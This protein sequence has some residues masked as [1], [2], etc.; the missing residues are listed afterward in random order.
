[1]N[2]PPP[3]LAAALAYQATPGRIQRPWTPAEIHYLISSSGRRTSIRKQAQRLGR[4]IPSV[5]GQLT[6]LRH[7]G[8]I[9]RAGRRKNTQ[10]RWTHDDDMRLLEMIH[11]G[12]P[13][14]LVA[15]RIGR[16]EDSVYQRVYQ[17]GETVTRLRARAIRTRTAEEVAAL[18]GRSSELV[19][20]WLRDGELKSKRG[21]SRPGRHLLIADA[22]LV[23]FLAYRPAW[24]DWEPDDMTDV[25]WRDAAQEARAQ[26]DGTWLTTAEVG[27]RL[28]AAP[29]T[30]IAWIHAQLLP[31]T[32][33]KRTFYIW[34]ADL[35]GFVPPS[36]TF[37]GERRAEAVRK[38][39]QMRAVP[40]TCNRCGG[41]RDR[42]PMKAWCKRC[43]NA[44]D[45]EYQ[46]RRRQQERAA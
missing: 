28:Y 31:A 35:V 33:R 46:R 24:P 7:E 11:G 36:E 34:S 39:H 19:R 2:T 45:V 8:H 37:H 25:D 29:N 44:Y 15:N 6:R 26:A 17:L 1:M 27:Q 38:S 42:G 21:V 18:F 10:A 41:P 22:A 43:K 9:R 4:S 40:T 12:I 23:D 5:R 30:V 14:A 16:S 20:R 3:R 13:V 32:L